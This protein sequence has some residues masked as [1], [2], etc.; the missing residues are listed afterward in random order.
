MAWKCALHVALPFVVAF[1]V[2]TRPGF[3]FCLFWNT[4]YKVSDPCLSRQYFSQKK[5]PFWLQLTYHRKDTWFCFHMSG[6]KGLEGRT[7]FKSEVMW[8]NKNTSVQ[9]IHIA[10]RRCK[11]FCR[12]IEKGVTG[13][14]ITQST[15]LDVSDYVKCVR[16]SRRAACDRRMVVSRRR[17]RAIVR[18][19]RTDGRVSS[20]RLQR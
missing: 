15:E 18:G 6:A 8:Y 3:L 19:G 9:D 5:V 12:T 11:N 16:C 20:C 7:M 2:L 13:G 4:G 17:G 1:L 14:E 10:E